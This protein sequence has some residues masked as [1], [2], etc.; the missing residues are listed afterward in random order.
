[1]LLVPG[2][3]ALSAARRARAFATAKAV[4]DGLAMLDT[5]WVHLVVSERAL[6]ADEATRLDRM[7]A[8]GPE[9]AA[10]LPGPSS[11]RCRIG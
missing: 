7:L 4:C 6:T 3:A 10:M 1:V 11:A 2:R 5:R 8:Y 9:V